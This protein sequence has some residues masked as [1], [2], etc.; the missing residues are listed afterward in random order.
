MTDEAE[1]DPESNGCHHTDRRLSDGT[2][3]PQRLP[4]SIS[5]VTHT[6]KAVE[7]QS[8]AIAAGVRMQ[9]FVSKISTAE[10]RLRQR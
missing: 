9:L 2:A 6:V 3:R 7:R 5:Q 1:P 8:R 10:E 4:A